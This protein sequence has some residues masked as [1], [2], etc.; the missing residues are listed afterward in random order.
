MQGHRVLRR[1]GGGV[2]LALSLSVTRVSSRPLC[3]SL[4]RSR[5]LSLSLI[6]V[7]VS[8]SRG[9]R[10]QLTQGAALILLALT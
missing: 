4:S 1:T 5:A 8:H 3:L 6:G 10:V 9:F 2:A 7:L